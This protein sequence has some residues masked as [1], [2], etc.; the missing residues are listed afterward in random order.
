MPPPGYQALR[1]NEDW[2]RYRPRAADGPVDA[3]KHIELDADGDAWLSLGGRADAR[4]EAWDGFGFG[5]ADPGNSDTFTL[6]RLTLHAD[7]HYGEHLRAFVEGRTAQSTDRD[8]P[9]GRRPVDVD[10][11]GLFQAFVDVSVPL[12]EADS[13]RLR[14]GRQSFLF[15]SQRLVSP[16]LWVNV[17]NAWDGTSLGLR[18]GDWS[19]EA[20]CTAFVVVDATGPNEADWDKTLYGVFANRPAAAGGRGWD[21]YLLGNTRPDVTVNGTRGDER[22]HTLGARNHGSLGGGFDGE[23]EGAW[24]SGRVGSGSVNAWFASGVMGRRFADAWLRPRVFVGLDAASG[25]DEPGGSVG[26]FHQLYPLGHAFLGYADAFGRQ[27]IA[28]AHVGVQLHP[29]PSTV[30]TATVHGFRALDRN[31]AAYAVNGAVARTGLRGHDLGQEIDLLLTHRCNRHL[32]VYLG[33]SHL[34]TGNALN[35]TGPTEDE[36]FAYLGAS[37][38]F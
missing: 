24:Q 31:D 23:L 6:T 11:L 15:G 3:I 27:N 30:L 35:G 7:L 13:A 21:L 17:W 2:S 20:F 4:F 1:Q 33:Y 16:L 10:T 8:L 12:G 28:A 26:T 36:D 19:V 25:D 37:L 29:A 32:D 22:R 9:G 38:V 34:F 14:I 5:A 18:L